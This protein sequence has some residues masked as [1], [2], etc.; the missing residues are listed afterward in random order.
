[1]RS[2]SSAHLCH[3]FF[4]ALGQLRCLPGLYRRP[5]LPG[6]KAL[7]HRHPPVPGVHFL[8]VI[9]LT[10]SKVHTFL[11]IF[12]SAFICVHLWLVKLFSIRDTLRISA[13]YFIKLIANC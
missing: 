2:E 9:T 4:N 3:Y 1:M 11:F 6:N 7:Q 8:C 5:P 10:R 13:V 12:S